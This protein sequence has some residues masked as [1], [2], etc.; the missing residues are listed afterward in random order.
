MHFEYDRTQNAYPATI[1]HQILD[2]SRWGGVTL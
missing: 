2:T 1:R